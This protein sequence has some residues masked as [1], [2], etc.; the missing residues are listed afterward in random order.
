[1]RFRAVILDRKFFENR[2]WH[3][4]NLLFIVVAVVVTVTVHRIIALS[5]YNQHKS[6]NKR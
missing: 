2:T 5:F 1:M 6:I 3:K 4:T